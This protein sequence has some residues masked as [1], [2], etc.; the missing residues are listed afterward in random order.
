MSKYVKE[1]M[2]DQLRS[3][4]DGSRSRP[5]PG[6]QGAGR[7]RRAPVPPRPAEEVDPA[8]GAEELAGPPRLLRHG[9]GGALEVSRGPVGAGLGGDGVAELAKEVSAQVKTLKKPEIKGGAVDG[10]VVGPEQVED[11]TKLPSREAVDRPGGRP[12]A[13]AGAANRGPGQR[14]RGQPD[15]PVEDDFRSGWRRGGTRWVRRAARPRPGLRLMAH[16][17]RTKVHSRQGAS[18]A[19]SGCFLICSV[20]VR[21]T[22]APRMIMI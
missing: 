14:T 12:G 16:P 4:L 22:N 8:P 1:L 5:D 15:G 21:L 13:G 6:P 9:H 2:M 7:H 19:Y 10:V 11:I 17:G 18:A 20:P 3:D